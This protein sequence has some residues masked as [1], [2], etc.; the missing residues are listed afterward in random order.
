MEDL[1]FEE[2]QKERTKAWEKR[3]REF[4]ERLK[5]PRLRI[6]VEAYYDL[7]KL[8]ISEANRLQMY[9]SFGMLTPLQSAKFQE[10]V[11]DLKRDEQRVAKLARDE[12]K[13]IPVWMSWLRHIKGVGPIM[14]AGLIAWVDD[15]GRFDTVSKLWQYSGFGKP[16]QKRVHGEKGNWNPRMRTHTWKIIKQILMAK[17][18]FYREH[19]D[20]A[21][22]QYLA[23]DD[24]KE[25]HKGKKGYKGHIDAMARRKVAKLFLAHLWEMWRKADG[26]EIKVPYVVEKLG[27]HI[28][29][30]PKFSVG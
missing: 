16:G 18:K 29:E 30:P 11:N 26:L 2:R 12:L 5:N 22:A 28:I 25:M 17:N 1:S 14:G 20:S 9:D 21:K 13:G 3:Q 6:L 24:L 19:Y 7:Q 8:R 4:F 27:H 23:R 10:I 15:I